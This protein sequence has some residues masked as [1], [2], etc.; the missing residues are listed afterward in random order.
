[1]LDFRVYFYFSS[2][3][4]AFFFSLS[5]FLRP[6][7]VQKQRKER[8]ITARNNN[9]WLLNDLAQAFPCGMSTVRGLKVLWQ[10]TR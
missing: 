6:L 9:F 10:R 3:F 4:F 5:I 2:T 7:H 8:F 1:M